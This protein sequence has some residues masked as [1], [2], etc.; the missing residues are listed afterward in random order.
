MIANAPIDRSFLAAQ[1]FGD[2][3]LEADIL[4][5]FLEQ[6]GELRP[7]ILNTDG[8]TSAG[9][10]LAALHKLKGSARAIGA[11]PLA[12]ASE[13]MEGLLA[14]APATANQPHRSALDGLERA[15]DN[16]CSFAAS[17]LP[18]NRRTGLAKS[19]ESR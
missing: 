11:G 7:A 10:R 17:L 13:Q 6:A 18:A 1:T 8:G 19:P 9:V 12:A 16:T 14:S 4:A 2:R 5:L 15:L 3:E